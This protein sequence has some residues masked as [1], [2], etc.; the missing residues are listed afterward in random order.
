MLKKIAKIKYNTE[1]EIVKIQQ[2]TTST[3]QPLIV[4]VTSPLLF[5]LT[6]TGSLRNRYS[7]ISVVSN[8]EPRTCFPHLYLKVD[9]FHRC[10]TM[11]PFLRRLARGWCQTADAYKSRTDQAEIGRGVDTSSSNTPSPPLHQP[12]PLNT[13]VCSGT[14]RLD[15][16]WDLSGSD[17]CSYSALSSLPTPQLSILLQRL[18]I[19]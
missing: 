7:Q 10:F 12:A 8:V 14:R 11:V 13:G 6:L 4:G 17:V 9:G 1:E 18:Y 3:A 19:W 5:G 2:V 15:G 16:L